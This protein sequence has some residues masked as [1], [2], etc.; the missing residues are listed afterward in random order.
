MYHLEL[1]LEYRQPIRQ[2]HVGVLAHP[3]VAIELDVMRE[4]LDV[5]VLQHHLKKKTFASIT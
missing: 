1:Q 3:R 2:Q 5:H 4:C